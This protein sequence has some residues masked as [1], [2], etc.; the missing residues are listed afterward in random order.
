MD[1]T[2]A[3][4]A[5]QAAWAL[6][7]AVVPA[8]HDPSDLFAL[9]LS[10]PPAL[11]VPCLRQLSAVSRS[12]S[13]SA[14]GHKRSAKLCAQGALRAA[15]SALARDPAGHSED[16]VLSAVLVPC[17]FQSGDRD[18]L[19]ASLVSACAHDSAA[20]VRE[21]AR[22][23]G[24]APG[25][26]LGDSALGELALSAACVSGCAEVAEL[27]ATPPLGVGH[28][29]AAAGDARALGFA[30]AGGHAGVV[31]VLAGERYRL[32][33]EDARRCRALQF[34]CGS[35]STEIVDIL[36]GP[37]FALGPDDAREAN[38]QA[39][40]SACSRGHAAI[41]ARLAQAPFFLGQ[42][43]ARSREVGVLMYAC[44]SGH[45]DI[46]RMLAEPPYSLGRE[47]VGP[48][49]AIACIHGN[50]EVI[51]V[52]SRPPYLQRTEEAR[53]IN[54]LALRSACS[55]GHVSVLQ[56]LAREPFL[57]GQEDAR[58]MDCECL[59]VACSKGF[60]PV[61]RALAQP[62]FSL[63]PDDARASNNGALI[64]ACENGNAEV[65]RVLSREP[66]CLGQED[67]RSSFV[68]SL[69]S[70]CYRGHREVVAVLSQPPYSL[71][72]DDARVRGSY[73]LLAACCGADAGVLELL[74]GPAFSLSHS[75]AVER[76]N[77]PLLFACV[78]GAS[79]VLRVLQREP[80]SV[81]TGRL[82]PRAEPDAELVNSLSCLDMDDEAV[83]LYLEV[84]RK[85]IQALEDGKTTRDDICQ[86]GGIEALVS[87]MA[88]L[89]SD[90]AVL[91]SS[92]SVLGSLSDT[93]AYADL[94]VNTGGVAVAVAGLRAHPEN[95]ALHEKT[96]ELLLNLSATD[97]VSRTLS[98]AGVIEL[99]LEALER[100]KYSVSIQYST[101]SLLG[102]IVVEG[103]EAV[104]KI[105]ALGGVDMVVSMMKENLK[106]KKLQ[107]SYCALLEGVSGAGHATSVV[108]CGGVFQLLQ[109]MEA[110]PHSIGL[111]TSICRAFSNICT[112]GRNCIRLLLR[113][114][115]VEAVLD[116][117]N[118]H[119][120]SPGLLCAALCTLGNMAAD[121]EAASRIVLLGGVQALLRALRRHDDDAVIKLVAPTALCFFVCHD[122]LAVDVARS[123]GAIEVMRKYRDAT[124]SRSFYHC[125]QCL[126]RSTEQIV[127]DAVRDGV[128]TNVYAPKACDRNCASFYCRKCS[129]VQRAARCWTCNTEDRMDRMRLPHM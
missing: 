28:E 74:A 58:A 64:R 57:L 72:Q 123:D 6:R 7:G 25:P 19:V 67:A 99:A 15:A 68:Q 91:I 43:D 59:R 54:N 111:H 112:E 101:C 33:R 41:V 1:T 95:E 23:L 127:H 35:G 119:E 73:A 75:D 103:G 52:L 66:F 56:A 129:V 39:L 44:K 71:G 114:R 90:A 70:A 13:A 55:G 128:C 16:A 53:G 47:D 122:E 107:K 20:A 17:V 30:C 87:A 27:L 5:L 69:R 93:Q 92:C 110:H 109:V 26:L 8:I 60:V 83:A 50:T 78:Q 62:P 61:V 84:L 63:G 124:E 120:E 32:G 76:G 86:C 14:L 80:L 49:L 102:N 40:C 89:Q 9:A 81:R 121:G 65:L 4:A 82:G 106:R 10:S 104:Q 2:E 98:R 22:R 31:R 45:A 117:V 37:L 48:G 24:P 113:M 108:T 88:S 38:N 18:L 85:V 34:A 21:L 125:V 97:C 46:V 94:I 116:T 42:T 115:G 12:F 51:D 96:L 11:L 77:A 29:A 105:V 36:A 118:A 100:W 126:E 3:E 79:E